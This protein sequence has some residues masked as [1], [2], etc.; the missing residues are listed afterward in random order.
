MYTRDGFN[1]RWQ[2]ARDEA[3]K[4]HPHLL[5]DFTFRDLKAKSVSDLEGAYRKNSKLPAIKRLLKQLATIAKLRSSRL[6]VGKIAQLM[7]GIMSGNG[8]A[9]TKKP[10][11]GGFTTL[12]IAL[13]I[14]LFPMVPGAGLEPAQRER[15]GILNPLC[16]PIPPSGLG[17]KVEARSGV[18]PD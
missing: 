14:L 9:D 17:K 1:C 15:R 11:V 5:F 3:Q 2:Q 7:L 13:I 8:I 18:E 6:L 12:L 16:L 4:K 10:P